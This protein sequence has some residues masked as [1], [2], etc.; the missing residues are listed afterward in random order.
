M[1]SNIK[2]L[3]L[4]FVLIFQGCLHSYLPRVKNCSVSEVKDDQIVFVVNQKIEEEVYI[5]DF[6]IMDLEGKNKRQLLNYPPEFS[7]WNI[8]RP[9]WLP[10]GKRLVFGAV[11]PEE[12]IK[13]YMIDFNKKRIFDMDKLFKKIDKLAGDFPSWSPDGKKITFPG[14]SGDLNLYIA[15]ADG[16]NIKKLININLH[17]AIS[18]PSFSLDGKKILFEFNNYKDESK[19]GLYTI[20]LIDGEWERLTYSHI[21]A[22]FSSNPSYSP[23][24]SKIVFEGRP[25][26]E[27]G[28]KTRIYIMDAD[29]K[30]IYRLTKDDDPKR[31]T[32]K[33][34]CWSPDGTK[35]V[36]VGTIRKEKGICDEIFIVNV[37]GKNLKRLTYSNQGIINWY[38]SFRPRPKS[39]EK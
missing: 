3:F 34:P 15:N 6:Y 18:Y 13:L 33:Q 11:L 19:N 14:S 23:D 39:N 2:I 20:D 26:G 27:Y 12:K 17:E 22:V 35:I 36:F 21:I 4:L 16:K 38:P 37:D 30:N 24:G 7:S 25:P 5:E 9:R 29:G 8:C 10:D 28:F 32:E 31:W 1:K